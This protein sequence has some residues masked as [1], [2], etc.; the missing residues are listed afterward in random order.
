MFVVDMWPFCFLFEGCLKFA[1]CTAGVMWQL[2][3]S[4]Q[5]SEH[6]RPRPVYNALTL[7]CTTPLGVFQMFEVYFFQFVLLEFPFSNIFFW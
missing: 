7:F 1:S 5:L 6:L 2:E 3:R 4:S